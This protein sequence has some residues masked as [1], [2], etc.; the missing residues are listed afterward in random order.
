MNKKKIQKSDSLKITE[1]VVP[2][3]LKMRAEIINLM[4]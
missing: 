1:E 4:D 3:N 2:E